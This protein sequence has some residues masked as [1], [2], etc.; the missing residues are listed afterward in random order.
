[1][2]LAYYARP[3]LQDL[4]KRTRTSVTQNLWRF[5]KQAS[6]TQFGWLWI[7]ALSIDQHSPEERSHQ[8]G[9]T[10]DIFS[11]AWR[12]VVWL[13]PAYECS[14]EAMR[15]L[16]EP[17]TLRLPPSQVDSDMKKAT[18]ALFVRPY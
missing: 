3:S 15:A 7:D 1:M 11:N 13:G 18:E 5:L 8:V 9:I 6:K 17:S 4:A 12:V 14:D 2:G 10:S 16:S